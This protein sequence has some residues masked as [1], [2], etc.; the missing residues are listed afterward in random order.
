MIRLITAPGDECPSRSTAGRGWPCRLSVTARIERWENAELSSRLNRHTSRNHR[1]IAPPLLLRHRAGS[2]PAGGRIVRQGR[3]R[4]FGHRYSPVSRMWAQQEASRLALKWARQRCH[5]GPANNTYTTS[6]RWRRG[7]C[8]IWAPEHGLSSQMA[9]AIRLFG[10]NHGGRQQG[11]SAS[12]MSAE[13]EFAGALRWI[14][15][16][17]RAGHFQLHGR[18]LRES[19]CDRRSVTLSFGNP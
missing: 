17:G 19:W 16:A 18:I 1:W 6:R 14:F 2:T 13:I 11:A 4:R 12:M 7:V 8:S 9:F 10:A 3:Y 5:L 15:P